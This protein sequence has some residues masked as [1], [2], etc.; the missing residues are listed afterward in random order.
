MSTNTSL[1]AEGFRQAVEEWLGSLR[2][3][4]IPYRVTSTRRSRS[5]QQRLYDRWLRGESALP[6]ARPGTSTHELGRAIDV[7][8]ETDEDTL[9]AADQAAELGI[10]WAGTSD[11]VHFEDGILSDV[12]ASREGTG[13]RDAIGLFEKAATAAGEV[14]PILTTVP[15]KGFAEDTKGS[16]GARIMCKL[17]VEAFCQR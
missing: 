14:F 10:A 15:T 11:F 6:A 5:E 9:D 4:G 12:P 17:G 7:V 16:L 8:F 2:A 1:L 13:F 3:Q